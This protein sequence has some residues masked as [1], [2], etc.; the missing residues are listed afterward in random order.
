[1]LFPDEAARSEHHGSTSKRGRQLSDMKYGK[2]LMY[3]SLPAPELGVSPSSFGWR[4]AASSR[5]CSESLDVHK[6]I[7]LEGIHPKGLRLT[8]SFSKEKSR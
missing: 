7:R 6:S 8:V 5:D 3:S 2:T 1:M 4:R